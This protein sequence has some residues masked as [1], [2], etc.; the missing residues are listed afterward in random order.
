MADSSH[1]DSLLVWCLA[2]FHTGLFV[3]IP[4][5][6]AHSTGALGDFLGG[7]STLVG[8]ALYLWL[9]AITW[10][11]NRRFLTTASLTADRTALIAAVKWGGVNGVA[12]FLGLV[13]VLAG[14]SFDVAFIVFAGVIGSV[15]AALVGAIVGGLF[16]GF[17]LLLFRV[18]RGV[19]ETSAATTDSDE[20]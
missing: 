15:L 11:T 13:A 7:L 4:V 10:W 9:W 2:S 17:D 6:V 3:L 5:T 8:L 1:P 18:A 20:T 16:L 14:V 19:N 12:F